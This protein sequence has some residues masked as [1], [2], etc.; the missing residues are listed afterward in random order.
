[1]RKREEEMWL[2]FIYTL[3]VI[4]AVGFIAAILG[5]GQD[6]AYSVFFKIVFYLALFYGCILGLA[7]FRRRSND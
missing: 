2:Q 1:M 5:F 6:G 4:V 3:L 7:W